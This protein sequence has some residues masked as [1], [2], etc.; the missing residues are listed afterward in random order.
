MAHALDE[1]KVEVTEIK[2]YVKKL[3]VEIPNRIVVL[4]YDKAFKEVRKTAKIQG[5]RP[6]HV[7]IKMLEKMYSKAILA[8]IGNKLINDGVEAA[9][10]KEELDIISRPTIEDAKEVEM[11]KPISFTAVVETMPETALPDYTGWEFTKEKV[12]IDDDMVDGFCTEIQERKA[13]MTPVEDRPSKEGDFVFIDYTGTV[14][15]KEVEELGGKN[16]Q[17]L[18]SHDD[19]YMLFEFQKEL[20]GM[21][22]GDEKE[23]TIKLPKQYP[24]PSLAEKD[25][26]FKVKMNIIKEKGVP[27]LTD[28][29]IASSTVFKTVEEFQ[30]RTRE[31]AERNADE[32][33]EKNLRQK[34][35][36]RFEKEIKLELPPSMVQKYADQSKKRIIDQNS[37]KS[38]VDVTTLPDFD[39]KALNE[40][41]QKEGEKNALEEIILSNVSKRE[42]LKADPEKIKAQLK[43][44][45]EYMVEKGEKP[46]QQFW[47]MSYAAAHYNVFMDTVYEFIISKV[48]IEDKW[49]ENKKVKKEKT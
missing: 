3:T 19:Y 2:P 16:K 39:S 24:N 12:K 14:E 49:I 28:E 13:V 43:E 1:L 29:L 6:G 10:T 35:M 30:K 32:Q 42:K 9:I 21:N 8:D 31:A 27:E 47:Q 40:M 5:F 22:K 15:G 7:P 33:S 23:F 26:L 34:I 36:E 17:V 11:D 45:S 41:C 18:V 38:G 20:A 25:A 46:D 37:K 48:K 4:E 44:L